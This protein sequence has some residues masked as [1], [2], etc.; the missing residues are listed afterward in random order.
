MAV[1]TEVVA[2]DRSSRERLNPIRLGGI[3]G[4]F[5]VGSALVLNVVAIAPAPAFDAPPGEIS[6][7][8][9]EQAGNLAVSDT[10]RYVVAILVPLFAVGLHRF[11]SGAVDG[12]H[13][14]WALLG[15]VGAIWISAVGTVAN[16]VEVAGV[17]QIE[18]LLDDPQLLRS[19]WSFGGTLFIAASLA[20]GTLV[21]GFS[22]AAYLTGVVP[23][24][25]TVLGAA[26]VATCY[27]GGIGVVSVLNG[28]W[29]QGPWLA[30][31]LLFSLWV[32]STSVVMIR[33]S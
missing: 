23:R 25:L 17:W 32:V 22:V 20:W 29:A 33:R 1:E 13:R 10:L 4:L 15:V 6:T 5:V 31:I 11:V 19:I 14:A 3:A 30:S 12:A 21:L 9:S 2:L 28:G 24:W 8:V 26:T 27:T 18:A 16:S 7:Y